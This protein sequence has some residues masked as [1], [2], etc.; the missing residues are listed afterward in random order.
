MTYRKPVRY[1]VSVHPSIALRQVRAIADDV[2]TFPLFTK[3]ASKKALA[4]LLENSTE[5]SP[6]SMNRYGR[7]LRPAA[8][9]LAQCIVEDYVAPIA[10][11]KYGIRLRVHPYAFVVD[12]DVKTQKGLARHVDSSDVTMNV[13]LGTTFEGGGLLFDEAMAGKTALIEQKIGRAIVHRGSVTHSAARLISGHRT[14]LILWCSAY[15]SK[16]AGVPRR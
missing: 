8:R 16:P 6:N 13:C 15:G 1:P 5:G 14:N 3:E 10:L 2:W 12:Y 4:F 7:G 9:D 11:D